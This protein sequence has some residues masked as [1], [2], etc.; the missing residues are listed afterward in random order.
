MKK[1]GEQVVTHELQYHSTEFEPESKGLQAGQERSLASSPAV[2]ASA[3]SAAG[4][5]SNRQSRT[6]PEGQENNTAVSYECKAGSRYTYAACAVKN[7][8]T[9]C[10]HHTTVEPPLNHPRIKTALWDYQ[11]LHTSAILQII[12]ITSEL[13]PLWLWLWVHVLILGFH[14]IKKCPEL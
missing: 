9:G 5:S 6:E 3:D 12:K 8:R 2:S 11:I 1:N 4:Y 13:R 14:S 10:M 7:L